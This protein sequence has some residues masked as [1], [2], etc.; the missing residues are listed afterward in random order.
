M[1]CETCG[2]CCS[3][4]YP[5]RLASGR[6]K[7]SHAFGR[8][9]WI[10]R[11]VGASPRSFR[12]VTAARVFI[13]PFGIIGGI[14][15]ESVR[16]AAKTFV[17][18]TDRYYDDSVSTRDFSYPSVDRVRFFLITF[19]GVRA[20]GADLGAVRDGHSKYSRLCGLAQEVLTKLRLAGERKSK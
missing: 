14:G 13:R 7:V 5:Q 10:G 11:S 15:H 2:R 1:Q 17:K 20:V 6:R 8:M 3:L 18:E 9:L 4:H 16:A 19:D 12:F